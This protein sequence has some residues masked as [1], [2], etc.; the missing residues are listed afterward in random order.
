VDFALAQSGWTMRTG[1][2][3]Y[4]APACYL[5][6]SD[7]TTVVCMRTLPTTTMISPVSGPPGA[8][9][10]HAD[11]HHMQSMNGIRPSARP[12]LTCT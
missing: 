6:L 7:H 2:L 3:L 9:L 10:E 5:V 12:Q 1:R 11:E 4:G 8:L